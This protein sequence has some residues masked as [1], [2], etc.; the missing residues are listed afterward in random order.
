MNTRRSALAPISGA[1]RRVLQKRGLKT[2]AA[3]IGVGV[4]SLV[5]AQWP[6]SDPGAMPQPRPENASI[7][8]EPTVIDYFPL[9]FGRPKRDAPAEE[10][11]RAF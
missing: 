4:V 5:A 9:Q 7:A 11:I 1:E 2:L 3:I 10:H 6:Q 8:Q